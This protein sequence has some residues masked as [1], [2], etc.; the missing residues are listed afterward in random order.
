MIYSRG[1]SQ[2]RV[3]VPNLDLLLSLSGQSLLTGGLQAF[4]IRA[5]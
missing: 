1:T 4:E 3:G 5:R 2:C